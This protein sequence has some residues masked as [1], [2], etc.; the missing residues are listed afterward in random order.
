MNT[1]EH[2]YTTNAGDEPLRVRL[3][4]QLTAARESRQL[5]M[6]ECGHALRLPVRVLRKLEAGDYSDIQ[7]GVYLRNYLDTYGSYV[8]VPEDILRDAVE[9]LAPREE[10]PQLVS[11]G[12]ISRSHYMWQRYT[13][14]AT[15]VVLTAV[16][17]VPLVWLGI[18]GG[19]DRELTH[20]EPLNS[21]PVAKQEVAMAASTGTAD[22]ATDTVEPSAARPAQS[23][24]PAGDN[25]RPLMASM[26][27][28]AALD[29]VTPVKPKM[30]DIKV[31]GSHVLSIALTRPSWV[32]ITT[33]DG[34][35]LEYSL[36]PA[37][38]ERTYHSSDAM[39]VNIGDVTGA[40][41]KLDD[42]PVDLQEYQRA[43]VARFRVDAHDGTVSVQS[44]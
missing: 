23:R 9:Q 34:D 41:V 5:D 17:V 13:T 22:A 6:S 43:N 31:P 35:R 19:L 38:A 36:L 30:P 32:E 39:Q 24:M 14:A 33:A 11:T 21:A 10:R 2:A 8:G 44:M 25:E 27:P 26:A 15:Y 42:K 29:S 18:K 4:R 40:T 20:L 3:G 12:G 37:G 28:F 7:H 1:G 16:I